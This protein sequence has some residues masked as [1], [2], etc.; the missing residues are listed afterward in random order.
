[1]RER[2]HYILTD[3]ITPCS[4][5]TTHR[6]LCY[7]LTNVCLHTQ[8]VVRY[9]AAIAL[10]SPQPVVNKIKT[11]AATTTVC[12]LTFL[13]AYFLGTLY[14]SAHVPNQYRCR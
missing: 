14:H 9:V 1:M 3:Y 8:I 2:P 13:L 7:D 5:G 6:M 12:R 11:A 4:T 10:V